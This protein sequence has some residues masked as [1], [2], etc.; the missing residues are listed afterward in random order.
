M[1]KRIYMRLPQKTLALSHDEDLKMRKTKQRHSPVFNP[2]TPLTPDAILSLQSTIGNQAV[3]R[4]IAQQSMAQT[5]STNPVGNATI[6][7]GKAKDKLKSAAS[8]I[9]SAFGGMSKKEKQALKAQFL[10][11]ETPENIA[12]AMPSE[13]TI[14]TSDEPPPPAAFAGDFDDAGSEEAHLY[15]DDGGLVNSHAYDDDGGLVNSHAY[16]DDGG[17]VNSH[18]YDDDGGLV[19]SHAY[20]DDGGLVNSHAYDDDGGLVNSHAYDDDGGLVN[21]HA[22]DDDGGLVNSHAY[23]DDGGLV[24]TPQID[25][26]A[27]PA[28]V[29]S[30]VKSAQVGTYYAH[31]QQKIGKNDNA[32]SLGKGKPVYKGRK[33]VAGSGHDLI[34]EEKLQ[35]WVGGIGPKAAWA[36]HIKSVAKG[37][38]VKYITNEQER[39]SYELKLDK[40]KHIFMWRGK[41]LDTSKFTRAISLGATI[42]GSAIF[43]MTTSGQI[44]LGDEGAEARLSKTDQNNPA[45]LQWLFKH[46]T[47]MAGG[48]VAAAGE[49]VFKNGKLVTISD[50]SGH[51]QPTKTAMLQLLHLFDSHGVDLKGV[52]IS[53]GNVDFDAYELLHPNKTA[54]VGDPTAV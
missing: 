12:P 33:L 45:L 5:I 30:G 16:D 4:L 27:L 1:P 7:R 35:P 6:S 28:Q 3:Q 10:G 22:Y 23:D 9:K 44:Y 17:L 11:T 37:A 49:I 36:G 25:P 34:A 40:Y 14:E 2:D 32:A 24:N 21:S 53:I 43:V 41:P 18:A 38:P 20:D 19:N 8:K 29:P 46:S 13:F 54:A 52:I 15:D 51:Y 47:F 42:A 39:A 48:E 26:D 31:Y 50:R